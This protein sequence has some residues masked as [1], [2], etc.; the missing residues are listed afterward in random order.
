MRQT[1]QQGWFV[2]GKNV[3]N[4]TGKQVQQALTVISM[5]PPDSRIS[6]FSQ[7]DDSDTR[8]RA[9]DWPAQHLVY[10][11]DL[12]MDPPSYEEASLQQPPSYST[13]QSYPLAPPPTYGEAVTTH[14]DLFPVLT[15]PTVPTVVISSPQNPG[16]IV[17]P[18]TQSLW[19][20][21]SCQQQAN[22]VSSR[23]DT[24]AT[25]SHLSHM[26]DKRPGFG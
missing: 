11:D 17:H 7:A 10:L 22:P 14:P 24:A 23:L 5:F 8:I 9:A 20:N 16:A 6:S 15:P 19:S 2:A 25:C 18:S 3:S 4:A 26:S 13:S 21:T 1:G 12:L